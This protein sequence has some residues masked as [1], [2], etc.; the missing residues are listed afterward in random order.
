MVQTMDAGPQQPLERLLAN[1]L[2]ALSKMFA[3]QVEA[4]KCSGW[5][6]R[7]RSQRY[8]LRRHALVSEPAEVRHGSFR[9][10][11]PKAQHELDE[12]QQSVTSTA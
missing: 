8:T 1:Q 12:K 9:T 6:H 7:F 3:E 4:L 11:Q 5:R 2:A 10:I